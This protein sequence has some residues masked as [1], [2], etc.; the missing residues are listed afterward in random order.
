MN[1]LSIAPMQDAALRGMHQW[2]TAGTPVPSQPRILIDDGR[3]ST[4]RRDEDG[5][6]VGGIRLPELEAPTAAYRGAAFGTGRAPLFGAA[7]PFSDDELRG[8]YPS[9]SAYRER[10][11][12]AVDALV[13]SGALRPEDA[14]AMRARADDVE[15][16]ID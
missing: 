15:L 5:N 13:A 10:W 1:R 7:L 6:A 12:A 2:L 14:A 8:R 3:P 9:R 11:C 4:I 16:P